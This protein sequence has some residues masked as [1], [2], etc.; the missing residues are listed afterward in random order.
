MNGFKES[1]IHSNSRTC[2]NVIKPGSGNSSNSKIGEKD[3]NG[4]EKDTEKDK[5]N[6]LG[7]SDRSIF[8]RNINLKD[9]KIN[10]N[11]G[12]GFVFSNDSA[13]EQ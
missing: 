12:G 5:S 13:K 11:A 1:E 7:E 10:G 2:P 4:K 3:K 9:F 8:L 6:S